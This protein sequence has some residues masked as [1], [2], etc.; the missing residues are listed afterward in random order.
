MGDLKLHKFIPV[1]ITMPSITLGAIAMFHNKISALIWTQNIA[2]LV[3]VGLISYFIVSNK[4][5]IKASKYNGIAIL[6]VFLFLLLTLL[7]SGMNGVHRWI[8]IG[9]MKF[10][11]SMILLPLS[12]IV[13]WRASQTKELWF[14]LA[15]ALAISILLAIQPDASQLT[16]FAVPMMILLCSKTNGKISR[17]FIIGIFSILVILSWVFLDSLPAVTY[18]EGIISLLNN[19]GFVWLTLGIIS[20]VILPI[21]FIL[22]P[23]RNLTLPSICVGLYF[24]IILISTIFGN[25]PVSLMGYGISPIIGYFIPITWYAE[26]KINS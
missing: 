9:I 16:G 5:N 22:F 2:C 26:S 20:L 12:I 19:M 17:L 24:I 1:I 11:V 10:N 13:L 21:P 7:D 8:S 14:T 15:I 18:V 25:F 4:W 23:P 6:I 3:I